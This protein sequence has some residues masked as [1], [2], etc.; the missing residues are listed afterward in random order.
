MRTATSVVGLVIA[1]AVIA[2][3]ALYFVVPGSAGVLTGLGLGTPGTVTVT[4][5]ERPEGRTGGREAGGCRGYFIQDD[6]TVRRDVAVPRSL[7]TA[8]THRRGRLLRDTVWAA[9]DSTPANW[10]VRLIPVTLVVALLVWS[11]RP[12]RPARPGGRASGAAQ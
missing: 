3:G 9:G 7:G 1:L 11:N 12:A 2:A 10:A 8:G 5:C 6:G 4:R